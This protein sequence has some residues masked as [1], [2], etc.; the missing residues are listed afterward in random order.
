MK[1]TAITRYKHCKLY[2]ILKRL[3]W[4]QAELARRS[5]VHYC[6]IGDI[7]NLVS[8]PTPEQADAI[9]RAV[10][11]AGE[12][13]DVLEEWPETF[14][15]LKRGYRREQTA[16]VPVERLLDHPEVLQ[17]AAPDPSDDVELDFMKLND[18]IKSLVGELSDR[19]MNV[20]YERHHNRRTYDSIAKQMGR[21]RERVRQI[22]H[23][24][25]R[26]LRR[27]AENKIIPLLIES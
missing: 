7:I 6:R 3:G 22:E 26:K 21:T 13:I 2:A 12:Y 17:I 24:A 14:E 18:E 1:I 27:I 4:S 10:G 11:A 5:G 25:L 9:Q 20:L 23:K 16:E 15:G 8:R 19:E